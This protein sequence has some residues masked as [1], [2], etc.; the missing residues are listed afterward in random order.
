MTAIRNGGSG[1]RG[2][3]DRT[4]FRWDSAT[5][6]LSRSHR[7]RLSLDFLR[8][9]N[10]LSL[11]TALCPVNDNNNI[12]ARDSRCC[13][14]SNDKGSG[15]DE[16]YDYVIAVIATLHSSGDIRAPRKFA[17]TLH[18]RVV[19]LINNDNSRAE[20]YDSVFV[21]LARLLQLR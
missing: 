19:V 17:P 9:A 8:P 2:G 15:S 5:R 21:A 14:I 6:G 13:L 18:A 11:F 20:T 10:A 3:C 12:Q 16:K 7:R 4:R 1:A